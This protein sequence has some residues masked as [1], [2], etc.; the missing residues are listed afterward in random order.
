M[1]LESVIIIV[2]TI[3]IILIFMYSLAQLNL[4]HNYLSS[5][6]TDKK[7]CEKFDFSNPDEIPFVT[8][9]LPVY[10]EMYVMERL[11]D[12]ISKIDYPKD[13]LEIQVLDDSTDE[14]VKSTHEQVE[15]LRQTGLDIKH[16]TRT[17]RSGFKAGALKEGLKVANGEYIAIFDADFLPGTRD[18][19]HRN[20]WCRVSEARRSSVASCASSAWLAPAATRSAASFSCSSRSARRLVCSGS[21]ASVNS[22][23]AS[24]EDVARCKASSCAG[25][26]SGKGREESSLVVSM[27]FCCVARL[28]SSSR[29][30]PSRTYRLAERS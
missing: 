5:K 14:T 22:S 13:K 12:N 9:Q 23:R 19:S 2:Y 15:K 24:T 17:D 6:K 20:S 18:T 25:P 29:R 28:A 16:I 21:S 30:S 27:I 3:A 7:E 10:N 11:L 4:L 1:I 8:I 26:S